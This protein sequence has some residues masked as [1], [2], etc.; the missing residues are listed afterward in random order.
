MI[1][2]VVASD[3][4]KSFFTNLLSQTTAKNILT[5]PMEAMPKYKIQPRMFEPVDIM[6]MVVVQGVGF[7]PTNSKEGRF[8]VCCV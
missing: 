8:T 1:M 6:L 2:K 7:E 5:N 4:C 3:K